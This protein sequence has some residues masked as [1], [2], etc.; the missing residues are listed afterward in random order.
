MQADRVSAFIDAYEEHACGVRRAAQEVLGDRS[1]AEDVAH[2]VFIAL[3]RDPERYDPGRG[4]LGGYLRLM[5]RS[6]ALDSVRSASAARR[7]RDRLAAATTLHERVQPSAATATVDQATIRTAVRG[8]P[9]AQRE[10]VALAFWG[11]YTSLE[12]AH[13]CEI[14]LGTVKSRV[15]LGLRRLREDEHLAAAY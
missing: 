14:P 12:I 5:A 8:L 3:W 9:R 7:A 6:R 15:R 13:S 4:G 11:D 2:E 1:Q 10:A